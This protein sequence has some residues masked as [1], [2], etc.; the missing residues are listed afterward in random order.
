MRS[1]RATSTATGSADLAIGVIGDDVGQLGNE[2]SVE[3]LYGG[4]KRLTAIPRPRAH[5]VADRCA[6]C[7]TSRSARRSLPVT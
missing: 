2:G 3:V 5:A 7:Q 6:R 4:P 1:R